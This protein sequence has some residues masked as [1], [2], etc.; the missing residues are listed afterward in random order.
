MSSSKN[1]VLKV[2]EESKDIK[3]FRL[4]SVSISQ[5]GVLSSS[6]ED[7]NSEKKKRE[8]E[9]YNKG[10]S[11][12]I[13]AGRLQILKEI[14]KELNL[15]RSLTEGVQRLK[16]EIYERIETQVVEMSLAIAR[17]V[18]YGATEQD[19]EI[20]VA[21]AKEAIKK[22]SDR[23]MLKIKINPVDYEVLNKRRTE[24][25]QCIDGI[26]SILFEVDESV[27]PGGCLIETNQGD[28]DARIESQIRVIE[29]E[30]KKQKS[31]VRG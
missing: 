5:D 28:V 19:R 30:M 8:E 4:K 25:V 16:E 12:G 18:I 21:T 10:V 3:P 14:E 31:E 11:D 24:L 20:V 17:K 2:N 23:E 15:I 26:K 13:Q 27:Q 22:A 29:G 7:H 6:K 9:T 1:R